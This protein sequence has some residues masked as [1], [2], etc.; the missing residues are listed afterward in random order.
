M[1]ESKSNDNKELPREE[2]T[3]LKVEVWKTAI[4]TQIHFN[5]LLIRMRT[6]VISVVLAVFGAA[7][8]A[9]REIH[10]TVLLPV[11]NWQI[12][13]SVVII[14]LGM[15]FLA[16]QWYIDANYYMRLLSGAV[17]FTENMDKSVKGL[18][19]TTEILKKVPHGKGKEIVNRYY[20]FPMVMG[21]V[22]I[23]V[24]LFIKNS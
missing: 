20:F 11:V 8:F 4:Q 17:S 22:A 16:A 7:I 9:F 5:D 19:L 1:I 6:T 18:G 14:F 10:T 21:F 12:H 2:L 3:Q 13:F 15:A 24:L 23:I